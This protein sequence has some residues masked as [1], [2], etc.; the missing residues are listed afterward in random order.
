MR[1]IFFYRSAAG[2]CPVED[3]VEGLGPKQAKKIAWVLKLVKELSIVPL[4]YLKKLEG[5]GDIW[6]IRAD[7]GGDAF[8]F[9]GFWDSGRLIILTNAFAKKTQRTPP[10]EIALAEQRKRDYLNRKRLP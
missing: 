5:A 1:E 3:F 2:A 4:Q 9:L 10:R 7:F 6:E 8:R